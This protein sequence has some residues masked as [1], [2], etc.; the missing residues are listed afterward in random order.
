[1]S[2]SLG[3][4]FGS[5]EILQILVVSHNI[6]WSQSSFKVMLPSLE[7]FV[8][9]EEFLVIDVVVELSGGEGAGVESN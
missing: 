8:D 3:E 1:M 5:T 2:L 7:S 9:G 4:E 6:N